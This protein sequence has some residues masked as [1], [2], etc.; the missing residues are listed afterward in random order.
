MNYNIGEA[1]SLKRGICIKDK[2]QRQHK[3][4]VSTTV[5]IVRIIIAR[6]FLSVIVIVIVINVGVSIAVV[7]QRRSVTTA[8]SFKPRTKQ[9]VPS[10]RTKSPLHCYNYC[11][12]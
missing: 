10:N 9:V 3:S 5:S 1:E 7:R 4:T 12:G 11:C 2:Y 8:T 6:N